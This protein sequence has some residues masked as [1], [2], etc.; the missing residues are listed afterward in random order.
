VAWRGNTGRL[1]V[2]S[3]VSSNV[4]RVLGETSS[5]ARAELG[6]GLLFRRFGDDILLGDFENMLPSMASGVSCS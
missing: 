2:A 3:E 6:L 4:E 1:G 5:G